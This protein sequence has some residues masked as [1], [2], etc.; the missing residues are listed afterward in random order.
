[1]IGVNWRLAGTLL[2]AQSSPQHRWTRCQHAAIAAGGVAD[3][4]GLRVREVPGG[5]AF[6]MPGV[7]SL[8]L[9]PISFQLP[10]FRE[11]N[12]EFCKFWPT[13]QNLPDQ[14]AATA[15][16]SEQFPAPLSGKGSLQ[17]I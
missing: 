7:C 2:Y 15:R 11:N 6:A 12:R 14:N 10:A 3:G 13:C 9:L 17:G 8:S 1:L 4:A 5:G 16:N